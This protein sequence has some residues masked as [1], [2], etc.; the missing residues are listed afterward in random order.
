M[1][2]NPHNKPVL[3]LLFPAVLLG[4]SLA[5][6]DRGETQLPAESE[7]ADTAATVPAQT[8]SA[9]VA[10]TDPMADPMNDPCASLTGQAMQDCRLRQDRMGQDEMGTLGEADRMEDIDDGMSDDGMPPPIDGD[11]MNEEPMDEDPMSEDP[12]PD[13]PMDEG[14]TE[15]DSSD[16]PT[17]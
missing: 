12:M 3:T 1:N 14:Q 7:T 4:L 15:Q 8:P 10:A 16:V 6:C 13:N 2:R 17:P 11:P 9:D 5:G